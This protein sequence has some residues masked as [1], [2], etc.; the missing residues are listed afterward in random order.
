MG[1]R[2]PP[3]G[4]PEF[5]VTTAAELISGNPGIEQQLATCLIRASLEVNTSVP[6]F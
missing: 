2:I 4:T 6:L 1:L 5:R 3:W